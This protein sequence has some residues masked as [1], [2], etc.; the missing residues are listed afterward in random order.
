[1]KRIW[2][3]L[4]VVGSFQS[5]ISISYTESLDVV[6]EQRIKAI[7][8]ETLLDVV[9]ISQQINSSIHDEIT[10]Q[11]IS[12]LL[13]SKKFIS[14]FLL[15]S[16][17]NTKEVKFALGAKMYLYC[18]DCCERKMLHKSLKNYDSLDYWQHEQFYE[19]RNLFDKNVTRWVNDEKYKKEIQSNISHLESI[20][21]QTA[22]FL[23]LIRH[24]KQMLS[25]AVNRESFEKN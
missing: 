19:N 13:Q 16:S 15:D 7:T 14:F 8:N 4:L 12:E 20:S 10:L 18:L 3:T 21:E 2:H 11:A 23:G 22:S 17:I 24:N 25:E 5:L 9:A 6:I 1:M